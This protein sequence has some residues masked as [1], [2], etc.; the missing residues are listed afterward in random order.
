M[1]DRQTINSMLDYLPGYAAER[2][3]FARRVADTRSPGVYYQS[4]DEA[5]AARLSRRR[6]FAETALLAM[7]AM[8][9]GRGFLHV[10]N[11][12]AMAAPRDSIPTVTGGEGAPFSAADIANYSLGVNRRGAFNAVPDGM[13]EP[14]NVNVRARPTEVAAPAADAPVQV[15]R[16]NVTALLDSIG[17]RIT[18]TKNVKGTLYIKFEDP[19]NPTLSFQAQP[20]IRIPPP[21]DPHAGRPMKPG[22]AGVYF[23][24]SAEHGYAR[25][26]D[27]RISADAQGRSY[28]DFRVL[29][30]AVRN[31]FAPSTEVAA[32]PREGAGTWTPRQGQLLSTGA[33]V[34][35]AAASDKM[36][37]RVPAPDPW[38][39]TVRPDGAERFAQPNIYRPEQRLADDT[40]QLSDRINVAARNI[41]ADF[42]FSDLVVPVTPHAQAGLRRAYNAMAAQ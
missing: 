41:D 31:R 26:L 16:E 42:D 27:P 21:N 40:A 37:D 4:G 17:A 36:Q 3:R 22:E 29:E 32:Q 25:Q 2:E 15:T 8:A 24:A 19:R 9:P 6:D 13:P 35:L 12:N 30:E 38:A 14:A 28:A 5:D 10:Q 1:V 39:A 20:Q 33:P 34:A 11:R 18:Q 23:D 7:N